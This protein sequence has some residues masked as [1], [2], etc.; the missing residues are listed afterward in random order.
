M[1]IRREV[2]IN[3]KG[4]SEVAWKIDLPKQE[5]KPGGTSMHQG[6]RMENFR[7]KRLPVLICR[8]IMVSKVKYN[9]GISLVGQLKLN[10]PLTKNS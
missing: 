7:K 6:E 3:L 9:K 2:S 8:L 4:Q 10:S 5:K 1:L